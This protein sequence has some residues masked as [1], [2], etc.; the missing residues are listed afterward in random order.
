LCGGRKVDLLMNE[1]PSYR[2]IYCRLSSIVEIYGH[3][4][5][6]LLKL[7]PMKV[8][9]KQEYGHTV[10]LEYGSWFLLLRCFLGCLYFGMFGGSVTVVTINDII[11]SGICL[12][13]CKYGAYLFAFNVQS[14]YQGFM[15]L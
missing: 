1:A 13:W 5:L 9:P 8:H 15:I 2:D 10:P 6:C 7:E 14:L 11:M 4:F 12:L 3:F